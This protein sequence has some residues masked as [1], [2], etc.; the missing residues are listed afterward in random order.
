MG[1]VEYD[2]NSEQD[3]SEA[4]SARMHQHLTRI[5]AIQTDDE[6]PWV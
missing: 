6:Y 5:H 3:V 4:F 1:L 2:M